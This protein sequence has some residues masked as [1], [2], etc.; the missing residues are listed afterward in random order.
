M[1][2]KPFYGFTVLLYDL[3][4][5]EEQMR[6]CSVTKEKDVAEIYLADR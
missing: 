5:I 1:L 2:Y 6:K 4:E 3:K